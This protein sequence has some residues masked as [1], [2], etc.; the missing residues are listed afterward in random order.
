[1]GERRAERR[2]GEALGE[3]RAE[4][5]LGE[6]LGERRAERRLGEALRGDVIVY[7]C[8]IRIYNKLKK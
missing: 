3:R 5:R 1:L 2:L 8:F 4:R 6:A 7:I